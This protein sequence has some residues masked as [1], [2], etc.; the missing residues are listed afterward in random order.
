LIVSPP[1]WPLAAALVPLAVMILN[2][3]PRP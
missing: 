1:V 3:P 2:L